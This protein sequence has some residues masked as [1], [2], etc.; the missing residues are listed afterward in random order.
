MLL[1]GLRFGSFCAGKN[2]VGKLV[3]CCFLYA[4]SVLGQTPKVAG[5]GPLFNLSLGYSYFNLGLPS[6]ERVSLN[7]ADASYTVDFRPRFGLSADVGYVR[8]S[9]V[10]N[11][12]HHA[13]VLS[14]LGGPVFYVS[15]KKGLTTYTHALLGGA[16]VGAAALTARGF[17]TGWASRFAWAI[18]GGTEFGISRSLAVRAGIDYMHTAYFDSSATLRGQH[19]FRTVVSLVYFFNSDARGGT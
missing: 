17:N 16:R 2:I 19:N 10:L 4:T 11:T 7:G 14:Y 13:Y 8:S 18:G 3:F 1:R 6:S 5:V 15:R 9:N 12:D